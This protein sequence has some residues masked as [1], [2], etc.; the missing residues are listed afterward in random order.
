MFNDNPRF[1]DVK[2]RAKHR[3]CRCVTCAELKTERLKA[4]TSGAAIDDWMLRYS[5]H[6]EEVRQWHIFEEYLKSLAVSSPENNVV[7]CYDDTQA[8]GLPRCTNRPLKNFGHERFNVV[9]WCMINYSD[10][11]SKDYIYTPKW[12]AEKGSNRLISMLHK[13]L[14]RTK[15]NYNKPSHKARTLWLIADSASDNKNNDLFAYCHMLVDSGW[16]DDVYLVF[17]PV[18]HTHNGVDSNHGVHNNTVGAYFS[19]DLGH[20]VQHYWKAWATTPPQASYLEKILDWKTFLST[21]LRPAAADIDDGNMHG[22]LAGWTKSSRNER[23]VRGFKVGRN[24][25]KTIELKWKVDPALEKEWRG[26]DGTPGS[27]GFCM[28]K[29]TP[30][31]LPSFVKNAELTEKKK[32]QLQDM[33]RTR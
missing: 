14:R 20:F 33:G 11:S 23:A 25:D 6:Q 28:L 22:A 1:K 21:S 13:S 30:E 12:T 18:G 32:K 3:H 15:S 7:L 16:F 8:I 5:Q 9:P 26:R 31:G 29:H 2:K 27:R 19:G 17:G 4:F 24:T 10:S